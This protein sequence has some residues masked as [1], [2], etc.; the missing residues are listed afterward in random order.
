MS[1]G[2]THSIDME[3]G[4]PLTRQLTT[5]TLSPEQFETLYLQPKMNAGPGLTRSVGN[6]TPLGVTSF[7]LALFPLSMDNLGFQGATSGSGLAAVG[8]FYA[9]AGIGLYIAA[10]LEWTLGNTFPMVV[11]GTFGGFWLSYAMLISPSMGI[12]AAFAPADMANNTIAAAAA[13]AA[14][15]E[16]CSGLAMYFMVWGLLCILYTLVALRTNV[17]FV[18]LFFGL[19]CS[20]ELLAAGYFHLGVGD[21][22]RAA[23]EFKASGAFGFF[24]CLMGIWVDIHLLLACVDFPFNIPLLDLSSIIKGKTQLVDREKMA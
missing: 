4:K 1:N 6:P 13:G 12:A 15:R 10:I 9:C 7:L 14:T 23:N 2:G 3:N 22:V 5:V 20:F 21:A 8:A 24:V 18:L 11:F 17:P 19:V 16:Y